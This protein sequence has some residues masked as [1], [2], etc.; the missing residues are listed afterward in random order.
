MNELKN[1]PE[2]QKK[3]FRLFIT[4]SSTSFLAAALLIYV[5]QEQV[6]D[7]LVVDSFWVNIL[8]GA[9]SFVAVTD[10]ILL[11]ILFGEDKAR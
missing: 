3:L 6:M 5:Y 11:K 9:L 7:Y 2:E 4:I 8:A 10:L 1:L